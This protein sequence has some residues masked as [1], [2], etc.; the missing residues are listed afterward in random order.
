MNTPLPNRVAVYAA[1]LV[2]VLGGLTPLIGNLDWTSTAG[3]LGGLAALSA[4]VYKWLDGWSKYERGVGT[5]LLPGDLDD[6]FDE[7][8]A[9]PIPEHVVEASNAPE[10]TT[11]KSSKRG[12]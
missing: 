2:A 1:A 5:A 3:I 4:V 10:G 11:L 9:E 8:T 12:D 7:E 6:E